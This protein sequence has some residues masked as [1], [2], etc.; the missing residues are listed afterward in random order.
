[1]IR[2]AAN[3]SDSKRNSPTFHSVR[4]LLMSKAVLLQVGYAVDKSINHRVC[5]AEEFLRRPAGMDTPLME[6]PNPLATAPRGAHFVR[7][8]TEVTLSLPQTRIIS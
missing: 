7:D 2:P 1:M 3:A 8:N 4:E 6:Q 5:R